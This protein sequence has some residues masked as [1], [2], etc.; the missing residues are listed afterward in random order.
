MVYHDRHTLDVD[1]Q[2]ELDAF[3]VFHGVNLAL[4]HQVEFTGYGNMAVTYKDERPD[5][6]VTLELP[7][8]EA[9]WRH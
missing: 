3:L 4:A 8:P 7:I 5:Y 6:I 1:V 9:L 2:G